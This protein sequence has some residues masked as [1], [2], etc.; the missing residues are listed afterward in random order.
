MSA[1]EATNKTEA[2]LYADVA[3]LAAIDRLPCSPGEREAAEWIAARFRE[4]GA[5][6]VIDEELIHG[7][8]FT[9]LGVLNGVAAAAGVGVLVG[10]RRVG[11]VVAAVCAAGVWQDLTGGPR[12]A[13]RRL[14]KRQNT[15]NVVASIGPEDAE[16][17]LIVH[18][19]HDAA[20]TSFIFDDSAAKFVIDHLPFLM[21]GRDRWPPLMGMVWG[22]PAA[23][24][25][26][27]LTGGKKTAAL[28]TAFAAGT[29]AVMADMIRQPVVPGANDNLSGV[30]VLLEVA[31]RLRDG[32][33]PPDGVRVILLSAG[34]EEANQEGML[35]F[36]RRHFPDLS[37]ERTSFL[38]LDTVGSP[39][40]VLIEGEGF[41]KMFEYPSHQ[42]ERVAAAAHDAGVRL[43]RGMR[44]TFATDG[45]VPLRQGYETASIGSMTEH[46]VPSNY[47]WPSD[48]AENV[49]YKSVSNAVSI[50]MATIARSAN[51]EMP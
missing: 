43:R 17:T 32:G 3:A 28:G 40:L 8:Y 26:S 22:G 49:D 47:H 45:L 38:C 24:A 37:P 27:A 41:L 12:R 46:L 42:K 21:N 36:A 51:G 25:V 13:L 29:A 15:T 7:T 30:A 18:A 19:H 1:G 44:F 16:H 39:E 6:V 20:R 35:A 34:A 31:R 9:P 50:V 4:T 11:G 48:T 5:R 33:G 23:I 14:L 10:R 2:A